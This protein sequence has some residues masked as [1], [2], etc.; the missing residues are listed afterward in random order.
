MQSVQAYNKSTA[1]LAAG[2]LCTIIVWGWGSFVNGHPLTPEAQGALQ[3]LI[4]VAAVLFG[5]ANKP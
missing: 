5:P 2:A 1:A 4:T 3:T